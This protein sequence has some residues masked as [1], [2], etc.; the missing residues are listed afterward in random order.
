[1][2]NEEYTKDNYT[3]AAWFH[4]NGSFSGHSINEHYLIS[5]HPTVKS[6]DSWGNRFYE[7]HDEY[8]TFVCN[9]YWEKNLLK[10]IIFF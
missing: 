4:E 1:M 3:T 5:I 2:R 7:T 6:T 8:N 9:L 10:K